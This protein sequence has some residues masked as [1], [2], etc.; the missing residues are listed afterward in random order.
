MILKAIQDLTFRKGKIVSSG[1]LFRSES[2]ALVTK[3]H[4]RKLNQ[5]EER[6][7]VNDYLKEACHV[8]GES[9]GLQNFRW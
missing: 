8:F 2:S 9:T 5:T 1:N 7:I 3:G 6:G 4:A